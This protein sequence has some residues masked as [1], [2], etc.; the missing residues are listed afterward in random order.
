MKKTSSLLACAAL[1]LAAPGVASAQVAV[2]SGPGM[3]DSVAEPPPLPAWATF[4]EK[5]TGSY[6]KPVLGI[7]GGFNYESRANINTTTQELLKLSPLKTAVATVLFGVEGKVADWASFHSEFRR[8][9]GPYGTSVWQGTVSLTAMDNW[10]RLEHWG[11]S[12]AGGIVSDP[13]SFDFV[14]A[15]VLDLFGADD[16]ILVP[17]LYS[18]ANRSQGVFARYT[19]KGL[20]AGLFFAAGNPLTTSLSYGFGGNIGLNGSLFA[21]PLAQLVNGVPRSGLEMDTLSPSLMYEHKYVEIRANAQFNWVNV[22]TETSQA[23]PLHGKLVR[24][25]VKGKIWDGHIQPFA[26]ISYRTNEMLLQS[27]PIDTA[28]LNPVGYSSTVFSGGLDINIKGASGLGANYAMVHQKTADSLSTTDHYLNVGAT[29]WVIPNVAASARYAKIVT[30][31]EGQGKRDGRPE[32]DA[33]FVVIRVV[34]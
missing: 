26:N 4:V 18:G 9:P 19:W 30:T 27:S 14:S 13:S 12:L 11:A 6:I 29:Y 1:T 2:G 24:A 10:V 33:L 34:L 32:R 5:R 21:S 17:L 7:S 3:E 31:T 23:V 8:D 16:Y 28:K 20:T 15:H 22:D 25:G